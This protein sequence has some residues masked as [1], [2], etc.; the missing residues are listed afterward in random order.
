MAA[1]GSGRLSDSSAGVTRQLEFQLDGDW[2]AAQF[3]SFLHAVRRVYDASLL[4]HLSRPSL[5]H[6]RSSKRGVALAFEHEAVQE[7]AAEAVGASAGGEEVSFT[8]RPTRLHFDPWLEPERLRSLVALELAHGITADFVRDRLG[9]IAPD[10]QLKLVK[11]QMS[12]KGIITLEGSGEIVEETGKLFQRLTLL[13]QRRVALKLDN[14]RKRRENVRDAMKDELE[15]TRELIQTLEEFLRLKWGD[16]FRS[17][18]EA[19]DAI[20]DVLSGAMTIYELMGSGN[21]LLLPSPA[22]A[23]VAVT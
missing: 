18:P 9:L 19:Q 3:E 10:L 1:E 21:V 16:D 11:V 23:D 17:R 15:V 5:A 22:E 4:A 13:N 7:A 2:T 12:S 8:Y 20:T 6:P 14:E